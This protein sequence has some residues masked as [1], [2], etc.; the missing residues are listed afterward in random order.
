MCVEMLPHQARDLSQFMLFFSE[1]GRNIVGK[2]GFNVE[3]CEKC[4]ET[5]PHFWALYGCFFVLS[6]RKKTLSQIGSILEIEP[7]SKPNGE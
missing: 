7:I 3:I 4:M 1:K 5:F 2:S 6:K